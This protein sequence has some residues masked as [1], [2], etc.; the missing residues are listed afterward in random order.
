MPDIRHLPPYIAF[1]GNLGAGKSTLARLWAETHE[2]D[3][4][5]EPVEQLLFV[6]DFFADMG[7][8]AFH[9]QLD[10]LIHKGTE[11]RRIAMATRPVNQDRWLGECLEVFSRKFCEDGQMTTREL[12]LLE[13][14]AAGLSLGCRK[15][16]LLVY[17][18][19]PVDLLH[20]RVLRRGRLHEA[21]VTRE[22][23]ADIEH[24]YERWI[25]S[26]TEVPVL[27]IDSSRAD[28]IHDTDARRET[29]ATIREALD[30]ATR[31]SAH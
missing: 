28:W 30:H 31:A 18:H 1:C 17:V 27:R 24:R 9:H 8:W 29:M 4:Y 19:A 3:V 21:Q 5:L 11:A 15:P 25:A 23:L 13:R 10:F 16:D 2:C 20:E 12:T 22:W 14:L 26:L 7:R 6:N